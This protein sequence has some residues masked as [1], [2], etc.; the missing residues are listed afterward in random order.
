MLIN[1]YEPY[2]PVCYHLINCTPISVHSCSPVFSS[3][4]FTSQDGME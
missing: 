1:I 4:M 2:L 3:L